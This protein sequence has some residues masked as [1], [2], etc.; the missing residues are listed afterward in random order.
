MSLQVNV[1]CL[2]F[3]VAHDLDVAQVTL[4]SARVLHVFFGLREGFE[5]DIDHSQCIEVATSTQMTI[6]LQQVP[7]SL[8]FIQF[9]HKF[10]ALTI[11]GR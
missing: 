11:I 6:T 3:P 2:Y 10:S 1:S 8:K 4:N 7:N 5:S 9:K